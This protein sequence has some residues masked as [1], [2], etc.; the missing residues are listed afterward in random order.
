MFAKRQSS[1]RKQVP[2]S[3]FYPAAPL[4]ER[5]QI[6]PLSSII[7]CLWWAICLRT[8]STGKEARRVEL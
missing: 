4:E 5:D 2:R 1:A 6:Q 7:G 8:Q 3:G